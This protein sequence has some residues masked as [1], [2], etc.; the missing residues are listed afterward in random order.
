MT[1]TE[2][3]TSNLKT[4][5]ALA[6]AVVLA[7]S[8]LV[9]APPKPAEAAFPGQNGRIAFTSSRD[10]NHEIYTMNPDGTDQKRLTTDPLLDDF[11][12]VS[13][14]GKQIAFT[15][16]RDG[17]FRIYTMNADGSNQKRLTNVDE[18]EFGQA[19]SPDGKKIAFTRRAASGLDFDIA[20]VSTDG[21]GLT[22]IEFGPG[23][24]SEPAF[25]VNGRIAYV[26]N[27]DGDREVYTMD[28]D[29]SNEKQLTKNDVFEGEPGWSPNGKKI[30]FTSQRDGGNTEI[31]KMNADGSSQK[32][33]TKNSVPD[34]QPAF[35]PNGKKI[36]FT[37]NVTIRK[38]N[39]DG[40]R[41][42]PITSN[43]PTDFD[44]DWG[45]ATQ[46]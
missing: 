26:D 11:P 29:G 36:A 42:K 5:A 13:P 22:P 24:Q 32:R 12:V 27:S 28:A 9:L 37:S 30:V 34:Q 41:N 16:N 25:S 17:K 14:D 23:D 45:V 31:Y 20:V 39:V 19:W 35:S 7:A 21:S 15:S 44:P 2:T 1:I 38:M 8:S 10:G 33:L 18:T 3:M 40:S 46:Q 4:K 43:G 6:A